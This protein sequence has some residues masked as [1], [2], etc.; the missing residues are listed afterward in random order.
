VN[1][2]DE[3]GEDLYERRSDMGHGPNVDLSRLKHALLPTLA[4]LDTKEGCK[5]IAPGC[6]NERELDHP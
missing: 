1:L 5:R 3:M 4:P 6:S 2:D